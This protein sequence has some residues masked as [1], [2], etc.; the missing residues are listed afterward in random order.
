MTKFVAIKL[1]CTKLSL[2]LVL[3]L[4]PTIL[5]AQIIITEIMYNPEGSDSGREW[6]EIYNSGSDSIDLSDYKLLENGTNHKLIS[7]NPESGDSLSIGSEKYAI[8]AD[9]STKFLAD[10][11]QSNLQNQL[12][13]DSVFSLNN[14]G[15]EISLV[16]LA[17]SAIS[18]VV[19]DPENWG[20]NGTGN[21]LQLNSETGNWI[22]ADPTPF[23]VNKTEAENEADIVSGDGSES[24]SSNSDLNSHVD[25]SN[26]THF[27]VSDLTDYKTKVDLKI[28]AG[29]YRYAVVN[30]PISFIFQHNQESDRGIKPKWSMGDGNSKSGKKITHYYSAPGVYNVVLNAENNDEMATARTKVFVSEPQIDLTFVQSG[31]HVDIM[32]KNKAKTEVNLGNFYFKFNN[33]TFKI[34]PDT[35]VDPNQTLILSHKSTGF[36][37]EQSSSELILYYPDD[38]K[39]VQKSLYNQAHNQ[40]SDSTNPNIR[41]DYEKLINYIDPEKVEEFRLI[42]EQLY[43]D[44]DLNLL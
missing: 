33:Q 34:A 28:S 27:A 24:T 2:L 32:L 37:T 36:E 29:R 14:T 18:T 26:S 41:S 17:G 30:S 15:E 16:D 11:P 7:H 19:Y 6:I 43:S 31:K 5:N 13:I 39:L 44:L 8:I 42:I 21:S 25:D 9:N 22:S 1:N 3:F 40:T 4:T 38:S 35:I 12:L 23:A 20:A 10:F